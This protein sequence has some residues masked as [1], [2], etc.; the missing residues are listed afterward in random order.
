MLKISEVET[1]GIRNGENVAVYA[2]HVF[3]RT[4]NPGSVRQEDRTSAR[5]I[6][7]NRVWRIVAILVIENDLEVGCGLRIGI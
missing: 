2:R 7:G 4:A 1:G 6:R 3:R 5:S